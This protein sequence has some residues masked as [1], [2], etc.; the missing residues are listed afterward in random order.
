M[1]IRLLP[2]VL[3]NQI[4]A[5]EVVDRPASVV[6]E[7]VENALDAGATRIRVVVEGGGRDLVQVDDD[8]AGIPME[9][10][11]LA[12]AAHATSKIAAPEDLEAIGTLGF[13]GEALASIGSVARLTIVSRPRTQDD[14]GVIEVDGGRVAP[15]RP[16]AGPPGTSVRVR[17]L[18][19]NVP[20]RRKFLRS[21]PT[22]AGRVIHLVETV[23]LAHPGV[24]FHLSHGGRTVLDLPATEDPGRR[25]RDVLGPEDA[26]QLLPISA[27]EALEDGHRLSAWG[28]VSRPASSRP[29]AREMRIYLN[30]RPIVDRSLLH[31]LREA[32]RG[33]L[34]PGRYPV[35]MLAVEMDPTQVDVN[36]HPAKSEVRFR[37]PSLVHQFVHRAVSR[38]LTAADLVPALPLAADPAPARA[39]TGGAAVADR[40]PPRPEDPAWGFAVGARLAAPAAPA[41]TPQPAATAP[42]AAEPG[43]PELRHAREVLQVHQAYLVLESPEGLLV[44]DQHALHERLMFEEIMARLAA[45]PLEKQRLLLPQVVEVGA[46]SAAQLEGLSPLLERLGFEASLAGPRSVAIHAVPSLL[47]SR[48]VEAGR[49]LAELLREPPES[50]AGRDA[51]AALHRVVD[52]MACKAAVKGGERLTPEELRVLLASRERL[53]R[54]TN[55]PHGRP[56]TLRIGLAELERHFGRR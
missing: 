9:E 40:A 33:L 28:A 20:A 42:F 6:K 54:A 47:A 10:L 55:C 39:W 27:E 49:F 3:V 14:A 26:A 56:T 41:A 13:R 19:A 25:L 38:A 17:T 1:P 50:G 24:A 5:G 51:E 7:L 48:R 37:Q 8:G 45:G 36:V 16:G 21:E 46:E 18:F 23:A 30:G 31:A 44:V 12:V 29:T 34:P 43:L 2:P 22:E 35:G 15:V 32:Y 4:A 11:P 53:E 52:M